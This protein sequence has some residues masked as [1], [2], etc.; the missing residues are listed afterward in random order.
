MREDSGDNIYYFTK[1]IWMRERQFPK[2][3][4]GY[5]FNQKQRVA[6]QAKTKDV[7]T[8]TM[9]NKDALKSVLLWDLHQSYL[10]HF[11]YLFQK[12]YS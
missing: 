10:S 4:L 6:G 2:G 5:Y 9:I 1:V 12:W 3:K 7:N 8:L 11:F